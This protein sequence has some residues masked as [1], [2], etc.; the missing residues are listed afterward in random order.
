MSFPKGLRLAFSFLGI[1]AG[2]G[3]G[4]H[5]ITD[6]YSS[7]MDFSG[8]FFLVK[9]TEGLFDKGIPVVP[10]DVEKAVDAIL[11]QKQQALELIKKKRIRPLLEDLDDD[12]ADQ[13]EEDGHTTNRVRRETTGNIIQQVSEISQVSQTS[14]QQIFGAGERKF[15]C[16]YFD[17]SGG[18]ENVIL[19]YD[20]YCT[21]YNIF[22]VKGGAG[23]KK[24][25]T[26]TS[27]AETNV[28]INL[29]G[30][31]GK[32]SSL[33][34]KELKSNDEFKKNGYYLLKLDKTKIPNANSSFTIEL[35]EP[36]DGKRHS[37]R[38]YHKKI[39]T[40]KIQAELNGDPWEDV[41][42]NFPS[43]LPSS[44]L[45]LK[46]VENVIA[47][48]VDSS[49][50]SSSS[51]SPSEGED[52]SYYF[53]SSNGN[54]DKLFVEEA[55]SLGSNGGSSSGGG[56]G[57]VSELSKKFDLS[58]LDKEPLEG[59][60]SDQGKKAEGAQNGDNKHY[61]FNN[62]S[63]FWNYK[64]GDM[65]T[66]YKSTQSKARRKRREAAETGKEEAQATFQVVSGALTYSYLSPRCV[67]K[68]NKAKKEFKPN[69]R[70]ESGGLL[71]IEAAKKKGY[72]K[73]KE[74]LPNHLLILIG[75]QGD[76]PATKK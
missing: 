33:V 69:L 8:T 26:S 46:K 4:A 55:W 9:V 16:R 62:Y 65:I 2:I 1:P 63:D 75:Y 47:T 12:L 6:Y 25:D 49:S 17:Y 14:T 51:S 27:N 70:K 60:K 20:P 23:A 32:T 30:L 28:V 67:T 38:V 21:M 42:F 73:V 11:K 13:S 68:E 15:W 34:G 56:T 50:S 3:V 53:K 45:I 64:V 57:G 41:K 71:E 76:S 10:K 29:T 35:S 52:V 59:F 5:Q 37:E 36:G 48:T 43:A 31:Q 58:S 72:C 39:A 66:L 74:G 19:E 18:K 24:V 44:Q 22:D 40:L 7:L 54:P 61:L